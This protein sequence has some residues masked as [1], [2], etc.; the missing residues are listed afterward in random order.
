MRNIN[1]YSDI[2]IVQVEQGGEILK[3]R[4]KIVSELILLIKAGFGNVEGLQTIRD[5][6]SGWII[7]EKLKSQNIPCGENFDRTMYEQA[8]QSRND[9][10]RRVQMKLL[11]LKSVQHQEYKRIK[12]EEVFRRGNY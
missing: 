4:V 6:E 10:L 3:S 5:Y 7:L 9:Y 8:A 12:N 2:G 1:E 11:Y